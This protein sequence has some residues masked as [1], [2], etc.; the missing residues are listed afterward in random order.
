[1]TLEEPDLQI[2]TAREDVLAWLQP[3]QSGAY[4][5][6]AELADGFLRF[7]ASETDLDLRTA[8]NPSACVHEARWY[9][10]GRETDDFPKPFCAEQRDDARVLACAALINM[11]AS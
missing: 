3:R 11:E 9:Y 6:N 4:D 5:S 8:R 1:M 7:I 2:A 10:A